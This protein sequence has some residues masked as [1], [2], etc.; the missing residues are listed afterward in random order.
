M[1]ITED[2]NN[3]I[4]KLKCNQAHSPCITTVYFNTLASS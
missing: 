2:K 1:H 3:L 4:N